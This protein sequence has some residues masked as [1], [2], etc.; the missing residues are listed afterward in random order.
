MSERVRAVYGGCYRRL[1]AQVYALTA[2]L[3]E[4]QDA[5]QEA[6]T[7]ALARPR[8]FERLDNP[9][10]WLRVVALNVARRRLRR[11]AHLDRLLRRPAPGPVTP[12]GLSADHV[13]LV[14]A[15]RRL[16]AP[17]RESVAL[18]H[19]ADLPVA[20]VAELTGVPV[21]TVKT[22]LA[23]GRARLAEL[24]ADDAGGTAPAP[25]TGGGSGVRP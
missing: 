21:G 15:L 23:R 25:R 16:P 19:L 22:R 24:L 5:V 3:A 8:A 18:H 14:A 12:D 11:R 13:A 4:A 20:E 17:Q 10:A 9:E 1:V 7:R 2:D 6:F